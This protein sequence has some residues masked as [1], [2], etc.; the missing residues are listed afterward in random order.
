MVVLE[1]LSVMAD[2]M[3]RTPSTPETASSTVL[4]T[5]DSSSAGAAPNC[6]MVTEMI[7][8]ST[9]GRRVIG[10]L[11]ND[12]Q[13]RNMMTI[14]MTIAGSGCRIDHADMFTAIRTLPGTGLADADERT[15]ASVISQSRTRHQAQPARACRG[16]RRQAR[17]SR[18][19]ASSGVPH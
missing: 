11:L 5:C 8:M 13:P 15:G 1:T 14:A 12:T 19:L 16:R 3:W 17:P 4:V 2:W 18:Q 7:G 10:S 6:V 9:L